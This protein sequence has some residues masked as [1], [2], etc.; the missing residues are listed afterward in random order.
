MWV[1]LVHSVTQ[2]E[3]SECVVQWDDQPEGGELQRAVSQRRVHAAHRWHGEESSTRLQGA[4][5]RQEGQWFLN[6]VEVQVCSLQTLTSKL[7]LFGGIFA[8]CMVWSSCIKMK[9]KEQVE[10]AEETWPVVIAHF[11]CCYCRKSRVWEKSC[12][13]GSTPLK[14]WS[15]SERRRNRSEAF[16]KRVR[17]YPRQTQG[18]LERF[19]SRSVKF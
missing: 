9:R 14:P 4:W 16:W 5:H 13:P 1:A 3:V 11:M 10:R 18:L 12:P 7:W 17:T 2:C 6:C 19:Q 15:W 8:F